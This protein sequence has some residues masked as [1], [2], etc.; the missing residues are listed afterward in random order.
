MESRALSSRCNVANDPSPPSDNDPDHIAAELFDRL[1]TMIWSTRGDGYF[2]YANERYLTY[3]DLTMEQASGWGWKDSVHPDDVDGVVEYWLGLIASGEDGEYQFRLGSPERGYRWS[4]SRASAHRD[5]RGNVLRWY[6]STLD[7]EDRQQ[8]ADRLEEARADLSHISRIATMGQ[9]TASIA[10]EVSQPL[11][12]ILVNGGACLRW[13]KRDEPDLEEVRTSVERIVA[14]AERATAIVRNLHALARREPPKRVFVDLN[15]VI[16]ETV[17]FVRA[18]LNR[19]GTILELQ[20]D[21]GVPQVTADRVQIQQL[22]INIVNNAI[23]A[24]AGC[25]DGN[26]RV[27]I[28]T[29]VIDAAQVA[30]DIAD[31]GPGIP[32]D[33]LESLFN[34]FFSTKANGMGM[35]LSIC[36]TIM[37]HHGGSI[38]VSNNP[39]RGATFHVAFPIPD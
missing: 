26:R 18:E 27:R 2:D 20:L 1:P 30:V 17:P 11:A 12:G 19:S 31:T 16:D 36:R 14:S 35:G 37:E 10:H 15:A 32:D 29:R 13:L 33:S 6:G 25:A 39:D 23:Q 38:G 21:R 24:M 8:A 7:I 34:P 3:V 28:G 4:I 5:S 22:L 9:L